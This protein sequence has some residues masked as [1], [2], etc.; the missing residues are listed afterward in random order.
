MAML[1]FISSG[2]PKVYH[3]LFAVHSSLYRILSLGGRGESV[4]VVTYTIHIIKSKNL[5]EARGEYPHMK[6]WY[7]TCIVLCFRQSVLCTY[8]TCMCSVGVPFA[9]SCAIHYPL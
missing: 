2:L 6:H 1:Q 3:T 8:S 7:N 9:G 4:L 5:G